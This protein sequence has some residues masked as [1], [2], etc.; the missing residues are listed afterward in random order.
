MKNLPIILTI[1]LLT[2][3]YRLFPET[4]PNFTPI[5]AIA[6]FSGTLMRGKWYYSLIPFLIMLGSDAIIGFHSMMPYVYGAFLLI[7]LMGRSIKIT[8]PKVLS[9]SI[10]GSLLFYLITNFGVW[11]STPMY[12]NDFAGLIQCY[13]AAIP[14]LHLTLLGDLFFNTAMFGSFYLVTNKKLANAK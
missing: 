9:V 10:V 12:S 14:F 11:L 7:Y 1:I 3:S 2:I 8:F 13:V 5:G 6:L 4:I